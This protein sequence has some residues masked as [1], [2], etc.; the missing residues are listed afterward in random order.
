MDFDIRKLSPNESNSY[1][2]LRLQCLKN[3]PTNFTSNYEDEKAKEKLF[4]QPFIEQANSNNFVIGAFYNNNLIGISGFQRYER[5][6]IDHRGIIIQVYVKP[7]FQGK[8]VGI[9]LI[10]FTLSEAFKIQGIE[11]VEIDVIESNTKAAK[12]YEKIGF[13]EYGIQ[14]HF[15]KIENNYYDHKM[16]MIFKNQ[17]LDSLT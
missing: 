5:L 3:Y 10:K 17:Y 12:V 6:K 16:M 7:Q 1:R 4:F 13:A 2:E 11:Q 15:L 14:K 9:N 8:S